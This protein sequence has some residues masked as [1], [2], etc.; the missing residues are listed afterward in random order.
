MIRDI[1]LCFTFFALGLA[2]FVA[3]FVVG[4]V[5]SVPQNTVV[6][7]STK[8]WDNKEICIEREIFP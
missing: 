3:G 8:T 6:T 5:T 1:R 2:L 4:T 7:V